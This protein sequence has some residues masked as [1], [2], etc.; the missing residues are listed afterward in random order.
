MEH[1]SCF[2]RCICLEYFARRI[3]LFSSLSSLFSFVLSCP[4][5]LPF[6]FPLLHTLLTLVT[7]CGSISFYP[8]SWIFLL[9]SSFFCSN[10]APFY[11]LA[12]TGSYLVVFGV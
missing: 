1:L 6:P 5:C 10:L 2:L 7:H 12:L 4:R 3:L 11:G 8:L 9:L